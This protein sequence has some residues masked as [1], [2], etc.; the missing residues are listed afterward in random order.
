MGIL[1]RKSERY[2]VAEVL[3]LF[4][5]FNR[6][7]RHDLKFGV[8]FNRVLLDRDFL[9]PQTAIVAN[10]F[11][12][13][14]YQNLDLTTAELQRT[15][16]STEGDKTLTTQ[17]NNVLGL[18]GQDSWEVASGVTINAGLR[19]DL[20]RLLLVPLRIASRVPRKSIAGRRCT[21]LGWRDGAAFSI[22][23]DGLQVVES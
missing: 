21:R 3:N 2:Q 8:D 1:D 4:R 7:G 5:D 17:S 22:E 6:G 12:Q 10:T 23:S 19:Y 18:F 20:D 13:N 14:N 11:Y 16:T 9:A 15:L